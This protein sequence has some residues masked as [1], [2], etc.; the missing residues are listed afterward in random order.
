[1]EKNQ[2]RVGPTHQSHG[3]NRGA[4]AV[5]SAFGQRWLPPCPRSW[6]HRH[7][8]HPPFPST[9]S[10][11]FKRSA[12]PKE[13]FLSSSSVHA[14]PLLSSPFASSTAAPDADTLEC[15]SNAAEQ[16]HHPHA[17]LLPLA[18]HC[19]ESSKPPHAVRRFHRDTSSTA[20][21][22][23]HRAPLVSPP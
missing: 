15:P 2:N 1:L 10:C 5:P 6:L 14:S 7:R 23:G 4:Q 12:P 8:F 11:G 17:A 20:A 3:P 21:I 22:S 16:E 19:E 13:L 18:V 9:A